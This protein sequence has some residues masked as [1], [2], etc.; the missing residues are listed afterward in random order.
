MPPRRK[1]HLFTKSGV[2]YALGTLAPGAAGLRRNSNS[3]SSANA[4]AVLSG[5][6]FYCMTCR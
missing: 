6:Q 4:A 3:N 5:S 2:Q 1:N